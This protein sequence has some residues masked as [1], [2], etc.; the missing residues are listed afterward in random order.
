MALHPNA[1][2][3]LFI[4][5]ASRSH[6]TTNHSRQDFSGREISSSQRILAENTRHSEKD[7]H[8][9]PRRDSKPQS[10]ETSSSWPTP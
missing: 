3:G 2:H 1:R 10:Q 4:L 6:T 9:R 7:K 5:E 8:P